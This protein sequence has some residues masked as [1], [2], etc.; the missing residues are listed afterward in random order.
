MIGIGNRQK[1]LE[2]KFPLDAE[3][4]DSQVLLP[5]I[6]PG[7]VELTI[8]S[9]WNIILVQIGLVLFILIVRHLPVLLLLHLTFTSRPSKPWSC[10]GT[11]VKSDLWTHLDA[12]APALSHC[13]HLLGQC[14]RL[15]LTESLSPS[16]S[17][18]S[19]ALDSTCPQAWTRHWSR[20]RPPCSSPPT[21]GSSCQSCWRNS[22]CHYRSAIAGCP[23]PLSETRTCESKHMVFTWVREKDH[24]H[25]CPTALSAIDSP[26]LQVAIKCCLALK[27]K[28]FTGNTVFCISL[29]W[30][31]SRKGLNA[32]MYFMNPSPSTSTRGLLLINTIWLLISSIRKAGVRQVDIRSH[33]WLRGKL[34]DQGL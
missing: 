5:V 32:S 11:N 18:L 7:L 24:M 2:F 17:S 30:P 33:P 25:I 19:L 22:S 29:V 9:T 28:Y 1:C 16:L 20:G 21:Q 26:K 13:I 4:F 27:V 15:P 23:H 10:A 34:T 14:H 31:M 3:M 8:L 6:G 12:S